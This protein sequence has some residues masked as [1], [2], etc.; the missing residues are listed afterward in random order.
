MSYKNKYL[1]YKIQYL[2]S[3]Q[4]LIGGGICDNVS[5]EKCYNEKKKDCF[6]HFNNKKCL[7][8]KM[9]FLELG[10]KTDYALEEILNEIIL[11][12]I[13]TS[14]NSI[15]KQILIQIIENKH[16]YLQEETNG[17]YNI[18]RKRLGDLVFDMITEKKNIFLQYSFGEF[19]EENFTLSDFYLELY[20]LLNKIKLENTT[21][22][23]EELINNGINDSNIINNN[24]L[25]FGLNDIQINEINLIKL[26]KVVKFL[27][28][29]SMYHDI[30]S[31]MKMYEINL[32][33]LGNISIFLD[34]K[35]NSSNNLKIKINRYSEYYQK[36][37]IIFE[38]DM[39]K[40]TTILDIYKIPNFPN[41]DINL[42]TIFRLAYKS[43]Y[44]KEIN[45][46]EEMIELAK[47]LVD[48]NLSSINDESDL[49]KSNISVELITKVRELTM[50]YA[51]YLIIN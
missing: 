10:K 23:V 14:N 37:I 49:S 48:K 40:I 6:W 38:F 31:K 12:I 15:N 24:L 41:I 16:K 33:E 46:I 43:L 44:K 36:N 51:S 9:S 20:F 25:E 21:K 29:F 13:N 35:Q 8:R 18:S 5:K 7:P 39:L 2:D 47:K 11:K 19:S 50:E 32:E 22:V 27:D 42:Y 34:Q 26:G 1:I 28:S 17:E 30:H 4:N 3:K 45:N